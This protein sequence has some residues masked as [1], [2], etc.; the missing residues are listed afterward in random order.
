MGS[1][2]ASG[3]TIGLALVRLETSLLDLLPR[4]SLPF[5]CPISVRPMGRGPYTSCP[6]RYLT[7]LL[8]S[9]AAV[10]AQGQDSWAWA[11]SASGDFTS[12]SAYDIAEKIM[13]N[14]RPVAQCN[15]VWK[16]QAHYR[17]QHFLWLA[18]Q[19]RLATRD[20]LHHRHIVS[21]NNCTR[22]P[23][24]TETTLHILRDCDA[25]K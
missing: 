5:L 3:L 18:S 13:G 16:T 14:P 2:L 8:D 20:L 9:S 24:S 6:F 4:K 1:L 7:I 21:E 22:C 23:N 10:P 17:T 12:K 19:D 25:A 15:W 11:H